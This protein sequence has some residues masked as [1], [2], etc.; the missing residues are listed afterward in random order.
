MLRVMRDP[1]A[2]NSRRDDM[3]KSAAPFLH[4]KIA[5][6]TF[7]PTENKPEVTGIKIVFVDAAARD[8]DDDD[9]NRPLIS[10]GVASSSSTGLGRPQTAPQLVQ[11]QARERFSDLT[12]SPHRLSKTEP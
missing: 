6:T 4:A 9:C 3:A 1:S 5:T 11:G 12:L 8:A 10:A 2:S 7:T